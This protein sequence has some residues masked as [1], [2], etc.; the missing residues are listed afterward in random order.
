MLQLLQTALEHAGYA[1]YSA[2]SSPRAH[3]N[4]YIQPPS[5][6]E[7]LPGVRGRQPPGGEHAGIATN[8]PPA[9]RNC[10]I[11]PSNAGKNTYSPRACCNCYRQPS[12]MQDMLH[13]VRQPALEHTGIAT[14]SP[15]ACRNCYRGVRGRQPR[16][17]E[18]AGIA[19]YSPSAC[20]TG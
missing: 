19:T 16:G 18:H 8:S 13:T 6:Q 12:S 3:R 14:Y 10:Y 11:Q 4:C 2:T 7:L 1:T 9:C 15:P 17:G 5:M 20:R